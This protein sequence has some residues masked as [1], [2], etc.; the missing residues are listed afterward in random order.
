MRQIKIG[1]FWVYKDTVIGKAIKLEEGQ[2]NTLG[3]IDSHDN[4]IDFWEDNPNFLNP[5]PE[6]RGS[7]YHIVP[8]GRVLYSKEEK[9]VIVY[10]DKVLFNEKIKRVIVEFFLLENVEILWKTDFHY[11][12]LSND[13]DDLFDDEYES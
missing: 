5:F 7:E 12:T 9:K 13:I 2:K 10:M 8:R 1:I 6:L 3:I 11:T 4:H